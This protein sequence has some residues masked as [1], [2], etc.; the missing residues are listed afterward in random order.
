MEI[1]GY[2]FKEIWFVDFEFNQPSGELPVPVCMVA[3]ELVAGRTIR[4]WQEEMVR[5]AKPPFS[6][7]ETSLYVAYYASAEIGC[8]YSLNWEAPVNL[9]DLFVEFRNLTNGNDPLLGAGLISALTWFGLD[10]IDAADKEEMRQLA[11]RGG[12]YS[13]A[14]KRH[15][16]DYC[17]SDVTALEK[18][19]NRMIE[20]G[21]FN[22][23]Q[24]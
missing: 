6:I 11:M 20:E 2:D 5:L 22:E 21:I 12:H 18:I 24:N 10:S 3:K 13:E 17:E 7:D 23:N 19:F 4:L 14:E 15:L 1:G 9:L 8:H 16:L